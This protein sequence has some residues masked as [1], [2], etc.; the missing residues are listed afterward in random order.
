MA[1]ERKRRSTFAPTLSWV[2]LFGRPV[3]RAPVG[4]ARH[5]ARRMAS[6]AL[7]VFAYWG[8][9]RTT[10]RQGFGA[11]SVSSIGSMISGL[12]LAGMGE[13]LEVVT[14]LFVLIPA[15]IGM[16][17]NIFG[18]LS[19][20]FATAM[21][22]GLFELSRDRE[23]VV[24]QNVSAAAVLTLG[25][26]VAMGLLA[27]AVAGLFGVETVSALDFTVV[28][29]VGGLLSSVVVLLLTLLLSVLSFRRRWD[30]DSV[31]G[32]VIT[33]IGDAV[34]MPALYLASFLVHIRIVTAVLAAMFLIVAV[35]AMIRG[36]TTGL[37]LARRIVQESSPILAVAIVLDLL[38][39]TVV[40]PRVE[41]VFLA[42]PAFLLVL[43]SFL[44]DIGALGS[45]AASR[46]GSRLHMGAVAPRALP[47]AVALLESTVVLA[48]GFGQYLLI[49]VLTLVLADVTGH[50]HPG[51]LRFV[52]II[53]TG[54]LLATV[55]AWIIGYY[56]GVVSHRFG[57]DPDNHTIPL[58]TSGMD[59]LGTICLV[60]A[61]AAF[62]VA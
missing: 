13:R 47:S 60:A 10:M 48:I 28:A 41:T 39:G 25:T 12:V 31:G 6:R 52:A 9:E 32:P 20:R 42:F 36:L 44:E 1:D 18:A 35:L 43:P 11:V 55:L 34:T 61:M 45:I 8:A 58:V 57:F 19:A 7:R 15:A 53:L 29:V 23:G 16:R 22:V 37:P 59:L 50:A 49:S 21:H 38:A 14:G 17:G 4:V 3:V 62:G 40:Q 2:R 56:A 26:S 5:T 54:A 30:L 46:L 33:M 51:A 27:R 24:Y